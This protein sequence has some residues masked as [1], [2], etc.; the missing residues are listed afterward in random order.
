MQVLFSI[1]MLA[2]L[3][4]MIPRALVSGKRIEEVLEMDPSISDK[5]TTKGSN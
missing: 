5:A 1:L 2:M 4:G 3:F